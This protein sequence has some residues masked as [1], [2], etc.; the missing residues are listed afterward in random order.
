MA[1][2]FTPV[3]KD[4]SINLELDLFNK[5]AEDLLA[6]NVTGVFVNGTSGE[7]VSLSCDER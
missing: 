7:S 4:G 2:T 1:A 6:Q 5:Y 3:N